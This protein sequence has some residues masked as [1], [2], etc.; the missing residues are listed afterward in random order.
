MSDIRPFT[1]LNPAAAPAAGPV[2]AV[3]QAQAAFFRQALAQVETVQ[4]VAARPAAA[5]PTEPSR[6]EAQAA[7][8]PLRPGSYLDIRI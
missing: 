3:R 2:P 8:R 1:S 5:A 7:D 6:T 4:Q